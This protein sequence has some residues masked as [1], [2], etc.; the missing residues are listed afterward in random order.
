MLK[1]SVCP[2]ADYLIRETTLLN[3][4]QGTDLSPIQPPA[5]PINLHFEIDDCCS[6]W[7]YGKDSFDFIHVCQMYG[8]VADWPAF[9]RESY[10]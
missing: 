2:P 1:S 8:S 6:P 7:T 4:M 9:Y 10:A 3:C 5:P